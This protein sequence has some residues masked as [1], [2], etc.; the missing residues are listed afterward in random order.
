MNQ[1]P[2]HMGK[3]SPAWGVGGGG[4][5]GTS[6]AELSRGNDDW[7]RAR[8]VSGIDYGEFFSFSRF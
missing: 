6:G 8:R 2:N 3:N 7:D 5:D 1:L 4:G